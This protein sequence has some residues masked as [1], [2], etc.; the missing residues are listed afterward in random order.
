MV[1]GTRCQFWVQLVCQFLWVCQF[2]VVQSE[3][4]LQKQQLQGVG[5]SPRKVS[6]SPWTS[7]PGLN[8]TCS[9]FPVFLSLQSLHFL[10]YPLSC[11]LQNLGKKSHSTTT[12]TDHDVTTLPASWAHYRLFT[13]KHVQWRTANIYMSCFIK[14]KCLDCQTLEARVETPYVL[15][16]MWP[17]INWVMC[18]WPLYWRQVL[19]QRAWCSL[20]EYKVKPPTADLAY[21][22]QH[23]W[24]PLGFT[25]GG[26]LYQLLLGE[27]QALPWTGHQL[28]TWINMKRQMNIWTHTHTHIYGQ[29]RVTNQP[30]EYVFGQWE[31]GGQNPW[32][33]I[34]PARKLN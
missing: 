19:Y 26:S 15:L 8:T 18:N 24:F 4:T 21:T 14:I 2:R 34:C 13:L 16:A 28:I 31:E 23:F 12:N 10:N 5:C 33:I 1:Q 17:G 11:S 3:A 32:R 7:S 22:F 6:P 9:T 30:G 27:K 20:A 25:G 29:F